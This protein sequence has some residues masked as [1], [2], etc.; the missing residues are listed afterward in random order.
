MKKDYTGK[1]I[2][3]SGGFDPLHVGHLRLL[4][5]AKS[6][7]GETGKL[8]VVVNCDRYLEQKKGRVFMTSA[9]RKEII[10]SLACVD[11]VYVLETDSMYPNEAIELLK[12]DVWANG[13]DVKGVESIPEAKICEKY[14]IDNI[15]IPTGEGEAYSSSV[16]H[17]QYSNQKPSN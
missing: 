12:P 6:L 16:L 3:I 7:V 11:E 14:G 1:T 4:K 9:H 8:L 17:E 13:G 15:F 10:E 2:G 5:K